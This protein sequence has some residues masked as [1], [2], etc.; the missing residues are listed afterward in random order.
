MSLPESILVRKETS[1]SKGEDLEGLACYYYN[2]SINKCSSQDNLQVVAV[3]TVI[4]FQIKVDIS[5]VSEP[6][7]FSD[8]VS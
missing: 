7:I 8:N 6:M 2:I 1:T 3:I 4:F 5:E